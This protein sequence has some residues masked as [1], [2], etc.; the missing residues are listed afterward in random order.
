MLLWCQPEEVAHPS[1]FGRFDVPESDQAHVEAA[2][3]Q[4][5]LYGC[6]GLKSAER[7]RKIRRPTTRGRV[8]HDPVLITAP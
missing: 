3:L 8:E 5:F 4:R 1:S 2:H 7:D 6:H